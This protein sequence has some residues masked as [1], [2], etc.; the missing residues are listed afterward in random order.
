MKV[1]RF[2]LNENLE[3]EFGENIDKSP[4]YQ[5]IETLFDE[6]IECENNEFFGEPATP[7]IISN[8]KNKFI[9]RLLNTYIKDF[10]RDAF[11]QGYAFHLGTSDGLNFDEWYEKN[12]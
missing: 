11:N 8:T 1:K 5:Q 9:K 3:A 12:I 7:S 2:N 6:N 4:L 10:A